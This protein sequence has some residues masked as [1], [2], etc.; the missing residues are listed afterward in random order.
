VAKLARAVIV[1]DPNR[2]RDLVF[3]E[4][5]E[6]APEHAVL[7]RNPACWEGGKL[8]AAVKRAIAAE[9]QDDQESGPAQT[10]TDTEGPTASEDAASGDDSAEPGGTADEQAA[11]TAKKT[12]ARKT[13]ASNRPRGR[14]AAGEGTSGE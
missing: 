8:P 1:R 14:D 12:A 13:A 10:T 9:E 6:P 3:N 11:P 7:I 4:G 2:H 5:E